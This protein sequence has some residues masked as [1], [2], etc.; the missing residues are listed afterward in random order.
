MPVVKP[1]R[2]KQ[3]V[4]DTTK[5]PMAETVAPVLD[6]D[7]IKKS[8]LDTVEGIAPKAPVETKL[9]AEAPPKKQRRAKLKAKDSSDKVIELSSVVGTT[10]LTVHTLF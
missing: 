9:S 1:P 2:P 8:G 10:I 7:P 3:S 5:Q 6:E 4:T